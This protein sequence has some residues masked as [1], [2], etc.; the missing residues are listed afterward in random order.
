[1]TRVIA[2][3]GGIGAGKSVVS[4]ILRCE[5]YDV[6]DCDREAKMLMDNDPVIKSR[7]CECI[8]PSAVVCDVI[9][10]RLISEVVFND[11]E[12]LN[13]LNA[14][15]H[16]GVRRHLSAWIA[17]RSGADKL[18]VET[19]ILYQSGLDRMV[20]EVWDVTAPA[21]VR[22]KRVMRRN[23]MDASAVQARIDAQDSFVPEKIH[24]VVHTLVNDGITALLPQ[25]KSLQ[26]R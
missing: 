26:A 10:R 5:G 6:Y 18:F 2:V 9:D 12:K 25:I 7:L 21:D 1:M 22:L 17:A 24:P 11:E 4:E 19:A 14:I 23:A 16:E 8:H 15:V 13:A 3:T 20:D